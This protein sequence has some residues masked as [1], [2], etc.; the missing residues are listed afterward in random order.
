MLKPL[1]SIVLIVVS[2]LQCQYSRSE[3]RG[4]TVV[5]D[6]TLISACRVKGGAIVCATHDMNRFPMKW[7]GARFL[8]SHCIPE[9]TLNDL[10]GECFKRYSILKDEFKL[11]SR[12]AAR[13]LDVSVPVCT[14]LEDHEVHP[15]C[16]EP[17][18]ENLRKF[19]VYT[20]GLGS[21]P[22]GIK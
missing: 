3:E 5:F 20:F 22:G 10:L 18:S 19:S 6:T 14:L 21:N 2:M 9:S 1:T 13:L 16:V 4:A 15:M 7:S 12:L 11:S 17:T 8:V